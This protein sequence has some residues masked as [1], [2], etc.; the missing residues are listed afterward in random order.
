MTNVNDL[1]EEDFTAAR[2]VWF[3]G[4]RRPVPRGVVVHKNIAPKPQRNEPTKDVDRLENY[5]KQIGSL[6]FT[7]KQKRRLVKKIR[8]ELGFGKS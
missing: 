8:K 6:K 2:W 5:S 7:A 4:K 3:R 1:P